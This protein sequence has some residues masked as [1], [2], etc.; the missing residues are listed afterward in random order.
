ME[1]RAQETSGSNSSFGPSGIENGLRRGGNSSTSKSS[2]MINRRSRSLGDGFAV[3]KLPQMKIRRSF[4]LAPASSKS[5][6]RRPDSDTRLGDELPKRDWNSC[7]PD[8][9]TP[10]GSSPASVNWGST[11]HHTMANGKGVVFPVRRR[12][13]QV[14][15]GSQTQARSSILIPAIHAI[16]RPISRI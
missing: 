8:K 1:A 2:S 10:G 11:H 12:Y 16:G 9:C 13:G 6:R 14:E 5:I 3:T 7:Q 15:G 4:P